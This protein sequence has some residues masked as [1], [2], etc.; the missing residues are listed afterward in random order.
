MVEA[1]DFDDVLR[2]VTSRDGFLEYLSIYNN[3]PGVSEKI[4]LPSL[5][6]LTPNVTRLPH[7]QASMPHSDP[8][9]IGVKRKPEKVP[10][11][12]ELLE[13]GYRLIE[14]DGYGCVTPTACQA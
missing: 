6:K 10:P 8:G 12:S 9:F 2:K 14:F 5:T 3:L 1:V 7:D 4:P 13:Q 11:I